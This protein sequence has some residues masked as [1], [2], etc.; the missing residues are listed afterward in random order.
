M[1]EFILL[2]R[3]ARTTPDFSLSNL[4]ENGRLD[5]VCRAIAN[6]FFIASSFRKDTILNVVLS[7][8]KSPPKCIT[9]NGDRLEIRMPDELSIA[10][11]IQNALKKGLSLRLHEE[12]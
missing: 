4:A 1:R 9:F 12:K 3:K 10:K 6:A 7:G 11:E 2:A 8:P 5:L